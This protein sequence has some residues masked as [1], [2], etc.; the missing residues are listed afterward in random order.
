MQKVSEKMSLQ[1][2][3]E[4]MGGKHFGNKVKEKHK[5]IAGDVG[6]KEGF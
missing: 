4:K 6:P 3:S 5:M 1:K 2:V